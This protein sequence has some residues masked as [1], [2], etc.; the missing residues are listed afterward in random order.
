L[1]NIAAET[2]GK[3]VEPVLRHAAVAGISESFLPRADEVIE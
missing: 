1:S 3:S 2:A